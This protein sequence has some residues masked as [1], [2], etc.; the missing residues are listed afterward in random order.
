MSKHIL[1][2]L[3]PD[4]L[5]AILALLGCLRSIEQAEPDWRPRIYW[6]GMPLRP[7]LVLS[8]VIERAAL[9]DGI[10]R[11]AAKL[12]EVHSFEGRPKLDY[13]KSEARNILE[14][15]CDPAQGRLRI[16]LL[17]ALMSDAVVKEDDEI[18]PTPFCAI[19]GQAQ[20]YFLLQFADVPNGIPPK[21]AKVSPEY[22]NSV[23]RL[24]EALF[25]EWER[26][27]PTQSFRWDPIEDRRYALRFKEPS[28]DQKVTIHGANRLA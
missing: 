3:E 21:T 28:S 27:D 8:K 4:N 14:R 24:D 6:D 15:A 23:T 7:V 10:A 1:Q 2:G 26:K 11:G 25:C 13:Q 12:A 19:F 22:L 5:L 16:D 17:G 18:Q 20:Q 9:L